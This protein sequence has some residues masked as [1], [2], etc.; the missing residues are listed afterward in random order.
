MIKQNSS[1]ST[2]PTSGKFSTSKNTIGVVVDVVLDE[3]N[4]WIKEKM[5]E[6]EIGKNTSVVGAVLVTD[7]AD[8]RTRDEQFTLA[9]PYDRNFINLP[10]KNDVVELIHTGGKIYYKNIQPT[11]NPNQT[12]NTKTIGEHRKYF[13]QIDGSYT[14]PSTGY[15][16]VLKSGPN[17]NSAPPFDDENYGKHYKIDKKLHRLKLYEG[18]TLIE[19]RFG[20]SI[21][22]SGYD[23]KDNKM[24]P[25]ITIRNRENEISKADKVTG[26]F[27][28]EDINRD[29]SIIS[30]S[31]GKKVIPFQ[32]GTVGKSGKSDFVTKPISFKNF[33]KTLDGD[34]IIMNTGRIVL[35]SRNKEMIFYSKSNM[36]VIGD[37]EWSWDFAKGITG[38]IG[39]N[40]HVT[41]NNYDFRVF[42]GFKGRCILGSGDNLQNI[43]KGND[44]IKWLAELVDLIM[45]NIYA[46]PAGPTK[47]GPANNNPKLAKL[48]A[49]LPTLLSKLNYTGNDPGSSRVGKDFKVPSADE[50]LVNYQQNVNAS[51]AN[52]LSSMPANPNSVEATIPVSVLTGTGIVNDD[53]TLTAQDYNIIQA[54][55]PD[56]PPTSIVE[57]P[58]SEEYETPIQNPKPVEC[59]STELNYDESLSGNYKLKHLSIAAVFRHP[60]V[61]QH[62]LSNG[63]IICNLKNLTQNVI[64]PLRAKFPGLI[65]NSGFRRGSGKSQHQR[66]E[67]VDIQ[68]PR[69]SPS[70]YLERAKWATANLPFDQ[71]I[72]EH[73]N[74]IWFH[75]SLKRN[76]PQRRQVLTMY[77]K[78]YQSGLKLYYK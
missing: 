39:G 51:T 55:P 75:F 43:P 77:K 30:I 15:N 8:F 23:N 40:W 16:T 7:T 10:I 5:P 65:I 1:L 46:T 19:S 26:E 57:T 71:F 42:A 70:E 9:L 68:W 72:F 33:P 62:G 66:G 52:L 49:Q 59:E 76:K 54:L 67:A 64:E 13:D 50:V 53:G 37:S 14:R 36:G 28:L 58:K 45:T 56:K 31:S 32:P 61:P 78:K 35:S 74:S 25:A 17:T 11:V 27:T 22:F 44:L 29:G 20:Q 6:L 48:K 60:I 73:G 69:I 12:A 18:D 21:R 41:T 63:E 38:D 47:P 2:S 24:Y 34:Q 3:S 4:K